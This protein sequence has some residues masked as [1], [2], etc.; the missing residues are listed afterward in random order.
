MINDSQVVLLGINE[1]VVNI[2]A[3]ITHSTPTLG[4]DY[5]MIMSTYFKRNECI[6]CVSQ[7]ATKLYA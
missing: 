3:A 7:D 4:D 2:E 1:P 6:S 5:C